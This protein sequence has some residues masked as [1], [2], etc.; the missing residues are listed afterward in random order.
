MHEEEHEEV[1]QGHVAE[2]Q[3][4]GLKSEQ[5]IFGNDDDDWQVAQDANQTDNQS[6]ASLSSQQISLNDS[7]KFPIKIIASLIEVKQTQSKIILIIGNR[8]DSHWLPLRG[9]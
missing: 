8:A 1:C 5:F 6:T 2:E 3:V 9:F 7:K 4:A